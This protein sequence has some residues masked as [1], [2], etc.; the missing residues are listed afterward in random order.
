MHTFSLVGPPSVG[1]LCI[2]YLP[3]PF[4]THVPVGLPVPARRSAWF[5]AL[6][7]Q[8][9]PCL[10]GNLAFFLVLILELEQTTTV[11]FLDLLP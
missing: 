2:A 5:R 1:V 3:T 10:P 7:T 8:T 4:H 6:T 9:C 11:Y